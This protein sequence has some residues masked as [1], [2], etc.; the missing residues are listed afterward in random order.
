MLS[1]RGK[2]WLLMLAVSIAFWVCFFYVC[3]ICFAS[4]AA[5][6]FFAAARGQ[7]DI[8]AYAATCQSAL[9][10]GNWQSELWRQAY[11]GAGIK[12][13]P[14]WRKA[15]RPTFK[16]YSPEYTGGKYI[17]RESYFRS[18]DSR[19]AFLGDYAAKIKRDY[20]YSY[21]H[22]DNF[23]LYFAGLYRGRLGS[24]ATDHRYFEKLART[25]VRLAPE[26][27]GTRWRAKLLAAYEYAGGRLE[28]WQREIILKQIKGADVE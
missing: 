26:I 14:E 12:A 16:A 1:E 27:F 18:Y 11:N 3:G 5:Q 21:K 8:N 23:W 20:P 2:A 10:T 24:W 19:D 15:G 13:P 17:A 4:T 28:P 25:A 9:E 7:P 6:E 22:R